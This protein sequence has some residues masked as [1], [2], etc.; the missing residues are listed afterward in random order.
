MNG[1]LILF[2]GTCVGLVGW[3]ILKKE[4]VLQFPLFYGSYIY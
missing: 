3:G 1:P 4:R 2:I